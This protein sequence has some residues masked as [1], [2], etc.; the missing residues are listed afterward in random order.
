MIIR[1]TNTL[2]YSS[3]N[4]FIVAIRSQYICSVAQKK[5]CFSVKCNNTPQRRIHRFAQAYIHTHIQEIAFHN[6]TV[7]Q[8]SKRPQTTL[9]NL[10]PKT[11]CLG[12]NKAIQ[13]HSYFFLTTYINRKL[14]FI[15]S[16]FYIYSAQAFSA[17]MEYFKY[18]AAGAIL[19][20]FPK[21]Q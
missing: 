16:T 6:A 5:S 9:M 2:V 1:R 15:I 20:K 19:V 12:W 4:T 3:P 21:M 17:I 8:V 18:E 13:Y 7:H 10:L 11:F 14:N